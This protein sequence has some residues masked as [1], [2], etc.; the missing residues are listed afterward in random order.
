MYC[1]VCWHW[2]AS[3]ITGDKL[4]IT[5]CMKM[6]DYGISHLWFWNWGRKMKKK[7][8]KKKKHKK[9]EVPYNPSI[10]EWESVVEVI[11]THWPILVATVVCTVKTNACNSGW[12]AIITLGVPWTSWSKETSI[13]YGILITV[14]VGRIRSSESQTKGKTDLVTK[15]ERNMF[16][17]LRF[18]LKRTRYVPLLYSSKLITN[19]NDWKISGV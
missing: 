18:V 17:L 5:F 10:V 13:A 19:N 6:N 1:I 7:N 3:C 15:K 11:F 14:I 9:E 4:I 16:I 2:I 8:N 12:W